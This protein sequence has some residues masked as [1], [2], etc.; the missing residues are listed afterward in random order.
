MLVNSEA[1]VGGGN[2]Q[3]SRSPRQLCLNNTFPD[4]GKYRVIV[5]LVSLWFPQA[6]LTGEPKGSA[7]I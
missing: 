3:Y 7:L 1:I 2:T 5:A 6:H 4:I